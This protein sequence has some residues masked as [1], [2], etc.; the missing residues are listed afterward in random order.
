M[1]RV[2]M[3]IGLNRIHAGWHAETGAVDGHMEGRRALPLGNFWGVSSAYFD[4]AARITE[5][6]CMHVHDHLQ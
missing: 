6:T 1:R 2:Y 5:S 3:G 4:D